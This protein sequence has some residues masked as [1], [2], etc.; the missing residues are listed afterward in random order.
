MSRGRGKKTSRKVTRLSDLHYEAERERVE[1]WVCLIKK[2]TCLIE[3][4][5][6]VEFSGSDPN[7]STFTPA[8]QLH[9]AKKMDKAAQKK[10][11]RNTL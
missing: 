4:A 2:K 3:V 5:E 8:D 7:I 9:V 11:P 1:E 6:D 10:K